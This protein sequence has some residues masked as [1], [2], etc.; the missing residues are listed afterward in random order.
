MGIANP[1]E[2]HPYNKIYLASWKLGVCIKNSIVAL[3]FSNP[4]KTNYLS[5]SLRKS[6]L[7]VEKLV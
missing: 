1:P 5:N 7:F 3:I 4:L 2:E 6:E